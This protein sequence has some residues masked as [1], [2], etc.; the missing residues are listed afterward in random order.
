MTRLLLS[1]GLLLAAAA[2]AAA[3]EPLTRLRV[4]G[5]DGEPAAGASILTASDR[6]EE[7]SLYGS[8]PREI[9]RAE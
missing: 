4:L 1:A 3:A 6:Y 9:R 2:V 7:L 8:L 5:P